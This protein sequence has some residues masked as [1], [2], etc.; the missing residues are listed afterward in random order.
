MTF[1]CTRTSRASF[2]PASESGGV[3]RPPRVLRTAGGKAPCS[4]RP[5]ASR[6]TLLRYSP[7]PECTCRFSP[8]NHASLARRSGVSST[9]RAWVCKGAMVARRSASATT[10]GEN[11]TH[12]PPTREPRRVCVA[13]GDANSVQWQHQGPSISGTPPCGVPARALVVGC[14]SPPMAATWP[15]LWL[16]P[17]P[18]P[19]PCWCSSP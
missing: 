19:C 1:A 15:G 2:T 5:P 13:L 11:M 7:L 12:T 4:S 18:C 6:A 17:G 16:H 10:P 3:Q 9:R 14:G 8:T